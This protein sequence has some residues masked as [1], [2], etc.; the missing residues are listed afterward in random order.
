MNP[1]LSDEDLHALYISKYWSGDNTATPA[2]MNGQKH[3][4]VV[5]LRAIYNEGVQHGREESRVG[6]EI[7]KT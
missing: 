6:T 3:R 4:S 7:Q 1:L 2:N 5:A